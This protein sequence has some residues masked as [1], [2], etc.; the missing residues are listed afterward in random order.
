MAVK[1]SMSVSPNER[2][3]ILLGTLY[4]YL[5]CREQLTLI[6]IDDYLRR[7]IEKRNLI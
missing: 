7:K 5:L 3:F 1:G 6:N 2:K 4:Q